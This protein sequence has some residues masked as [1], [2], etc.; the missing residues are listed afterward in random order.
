MNRFS[1]NYLQLQLNK[2]N[3]K[4]QSA[5]KFASKF[6]QID[7][8]RPNSTTSVASIDAIKKTTNALH[9][10]SIVNQQQRKT[11]C[12]LCN[13][14]HNSNKTHSIA[15]SKHYIQTKTRTLARSQGKYL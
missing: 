13:T 15:S 9:I 4:L 8:K 6:N 2:N 12:Y 3:F 10:P 1:G 5:F 7:F 14:T 11:K